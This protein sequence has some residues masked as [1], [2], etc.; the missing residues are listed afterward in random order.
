MMR[1]R[2]FITL[3]GGAAAPAAR[4]RTGLRWGSFIV[5]NPSSA[6]SL[7]HLVSKHKQF[8]RYVETERFCGLKVYH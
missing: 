5:A 8:V 3:L 7:D 4:C 6:A 1:R 2:K